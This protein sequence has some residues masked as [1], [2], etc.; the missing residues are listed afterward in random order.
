MNPCIDSS[1][2]SSMLASPRPPYSF[3]F[4][5]FLEKKNL[6]RTAQICCFK[7]LTKVDMLLKNKN[8]NI[9]FTTYRI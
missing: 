6:Q 2:Q 4:F 5:F 8:K 3:F 1:T 9:S 7:Q